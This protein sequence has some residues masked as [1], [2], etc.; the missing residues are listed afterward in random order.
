MKSFLIPGIILY[1][2]QEIIGGKNIKRICAWCGKELD[3]TEGDKEETIISHGICDDCKSNILFQ[4]GVKINEFLSDLKDPVIVIGADNQI[5]AANK[6]AGIVLNKNVKDLKG[7]YAGDV[8]EC[9]NARLPEGCGKTVHCLGC[10]L[11][12]SITY[13]NDTGNSLQRIPAT[14]SLYDA[15]KKE[16]AKFLVSTEKVG[17]IVLLRIDEKIVYTNPDSQ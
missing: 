16:S 8:I 17:D 15:D 5:F 6:K 3:S 13:T 11:R 10:A 12:Q 2:W 1:F 14:F 9:E 7:L 4:D